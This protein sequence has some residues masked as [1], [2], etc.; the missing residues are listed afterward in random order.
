MLSVLP[1]H[2]AAMARFALATG[3]RESNG[4]LLR[5]NHVRL[6]AKQPSAWIDGEDAKSGERIS[7]ALNDDAVN[8]LNGQRA[9]HGDVVFIYRG[10]PVTR[11]SN[12]AWYRALKKV[13]LEWFR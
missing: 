7:V 9:Q 10:K 11:C 4:R 6:D 13:G 3:L 12:S 1:T 5:W 2:L 8:V